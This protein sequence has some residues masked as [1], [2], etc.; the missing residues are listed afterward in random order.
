LSGVLATAS[1][2]PL[3]REHLKL[4][5]IEVSEIAPVCGLARAHRLAIGLLA[6]VLLVAAAARL[7]AAYGPKHAS[8]YEYV[9]AHRQPGELII[10]LGPPEA[11]LVLGSV[12]ELR[13]L[14]G[15][16]GSSRMVRT[17]REDDQGRIVD[18]WAGMEAIQ[19]VKDLCAV[20]ADD[21]RAWAVVDSGMTREA[22]RK[23][24]RRGKMKSLG[25]MREVLEGATSEELVTSEGIF[26]LRALD[27]ADWS[28]PAQRE[29]RERLSS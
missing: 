9:E 28:R 24:E 19:T 16:E 1:R 29:C 23:V 18:Y 27:V 25:P 26:V 15:E 17:L 21:K 2:S 4:G 13:Y 7:M 6:G 20:L 5:V 12:P 3:A 8:A 10:S 11:Y 22:W 14:A